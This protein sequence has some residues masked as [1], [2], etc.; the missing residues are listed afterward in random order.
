MLQAIE[1]GLDFINALVLPKANAKR[2]LAAKKKYGDNEL[3]QV[4]LGGQTMLISEPILHQ[5]IESGLWGLLEQS[6][7][8]GSQ[9]DTMLKN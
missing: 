2:L 4:L 6:A 9:L 7:E 5:L 8:R 1:A 3:V